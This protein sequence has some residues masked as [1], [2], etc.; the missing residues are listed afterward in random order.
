CPGSYDLSI[1]G[2]KFAGISQRRVRKG[3]AV[4]I[5]LCVTG[6]G[7]QRA[8][9]VK[10]FYEHAKY[11]ESEKF[12]FPDVQPEVMAS[13]SELLNVELTIQDVMF[14]FLTTL[15]NLSGK[16]YTEQLHDDELEWFQGYY[17]R[18]IDRNR[19]VVKL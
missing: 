2:K 6:S 7:Q 11:N 4:Q 10:E 15:H 14:R 5:Y 13:L 3:V 1:N 19:K 17:E 18:M 9:L 16:I 12:V 8:Q